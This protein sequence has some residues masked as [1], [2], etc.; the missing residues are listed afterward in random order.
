MKVLITT[1]CSMLLVAGMVITP[2]HAGPPSSG[3]RMFALAMG[4]TIEKVDPA[5]SSI[6][7]RTDSGEKEYLLVMDVSEL[8]GLTPGDRVRC[9]IYADGRVTK[10]V[11]T[12][13]LPQE[14]PAPEPKG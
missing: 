6:T 13:P 11:K 2:S 9:E 12:T 1:L 3:E 14:S 10:I 7:L 4:G 5:G 8:A